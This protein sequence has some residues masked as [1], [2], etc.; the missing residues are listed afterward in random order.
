VEWKDQEEFAEVVQ[1]GVFTHVEAA[2]IRAEGQRVI[3]TL[4]TLLP[5]GWESWK[6][7]PS[8]PLPTLP[9]GWDRT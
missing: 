4:D 8:W 5:T 9:T 1:L 7:D 6:P 2:A 3:D